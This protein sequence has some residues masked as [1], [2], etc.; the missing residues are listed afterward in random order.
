MSLQQRLKPLAARPPWPKKA[1]PKS[2]QRNKRPSIAR[3]L[4]L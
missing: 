4:A 1:V 3:R 2:K